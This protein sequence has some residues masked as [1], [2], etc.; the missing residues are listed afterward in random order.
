MSG[1]DFITGF[2]PRPNIRSS[3]VETLQAAVTS[4]Q[5]EPGQVYSA[6]KL[7]AQFGVSAT[8]VRE[9]MLDLVRDGLV[10]AVPNRGFRVRELSDRELDELCEVRLM[11][12][13]P[14]VSRVAAMEIDGA[15]LGRLRALARETETAANAVDLVTHSRADLEFHTQLIALAGNTNL[16]AL[17][18]D[19][20]K[21]S[22]LHGLALR[23]NH[24]QLI[25]SAREHNSLVDLVANH[26]SLA[27]EA[28]MT[29]HISDVRKVWSD[30]PSARSG[31]DSAS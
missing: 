11:I 9:A 15:T 10:D 19:L 28:L 20:R 12:E 17:V 5:L 13:V 22:R 3:I 21:R 31:A 16:V 25:E 4:G 14:T 23:T 27:V 2:E 8:P 24:E 18:R 1:I 26:D 30:H 29:K 7:A 6:P